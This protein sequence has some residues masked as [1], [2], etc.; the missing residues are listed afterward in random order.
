MLPIILN[1]KNV[2]IVVFGYGKASQMK[3]KGILKAG[4][5]CHVISPDLNEEAVETTQLTFENAQYDRSHLAKGQLVIAATASPQQNAVIVE[6]ARALGKLALN[7][8]DG[9]N[10]DFHMMS[11]RKN[12]PVTVA[13]ST[14]SCAPKE[15]K[16]LIEEL[17]EVIDDETVEKIGLLGDLRKKIKELGYSPI[18]PI[19]NEMTHL[20]IEDLKEL[21]DLSI[22]ALDNEIK[23]V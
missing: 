23:K 22:K 9:L 3:V 13:L 17:M 4:V 10:S 18:K 16:R 21:N 12:G 14:G 1:S 2:S 7:L 5:T 15:S 8:S 11:W 6:E 20:S 19:I